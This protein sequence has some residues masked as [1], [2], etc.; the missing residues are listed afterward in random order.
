MEKLQPW[1]ELS[2]GPVEELYAQSVKYQDVPTHLVLNAV[3]ELKGP[4]YLGDPNLYPEE[5]D[6]IKGLIQRLSIYY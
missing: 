6:E 1:V 2:S 3:E 5:R 4:Y